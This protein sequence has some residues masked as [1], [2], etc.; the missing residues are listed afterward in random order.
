MRQSDLL[1]G[2]GRLLQ[3]HES[4]PVNLIG[5]TQSH[6]V[7]LALQ[8]SDLTVVQVSANTEAYLG[9]SPQV[10]LEK[11]FLEHLAPTSIE[12]LQRSAKNCGEHPSYISIAITTPK[13]V[14]SFDG[15]IHRIADCMVLE[16]EPAENCST[17]TLMSL[18][19]QIQ[20]VM[21]R[22]RHEQDITAFLQAAVNEIQGLTN[23]D[24]VMVYQ[25]DNHQAGAVVAE[26]KPS[27][28]ISYLGLHYPATDI[29]A[30]VRQLYQQ[31]L[32]RVIPDLTAPPIELV[33]PF[34]ESPLDLR[35]AILRGVDPCCISYHQN[36]DV[37][38]LMVIALVKNEQL[39]GLIACHHP[40]AKLVP[41][42]VRAACEILGHFIGAELANKVN[43]HELDDL[44]A[45]KSIQADFI[46]SIAS[47]KDFK[48]ALIHPEPSL[49]EV[50]RAPGAA[51]CLDDDI[52]L[53]GNTP[54]L[55]VVEALIKWVMADLDTDIFHTDSLCHHY[56]EAL[57]F[58]AVASGLLVLKISQLRRY[59]ILWFRPE[60]L[61]TIHWAGDPRSSIYTTEDGQV[62][63]CPRTSFERWQEMVQATATPWHPAE[64]AN[65]SALKH[66]IVGIVLNKAD[67]LAQMNLDLE[68]SNR[69]LDSFAYA[70][71]HD[72]KE[73]L[74]GI[75][76]FSNL[77]L[78]RYGQVL[79][80][81]GVKRLKTLVKLAHR[82]DDL[83]DALLRFSRLGQTELHPGPTDLNTL[84]PK[85]LEV[86][87]ASRPEG[88]ELPPIR[89]SRSFPMVNGDPVL[90]AEVFSNL[91]SNA[92]KYTNKPQPSIEIGVLDVD[93]QVSKARA[94]AAFMT[95]P[96]TCVLY[97][98]DDGIGIPPQHLQTVFRL[99]K[100]LH[101]RD[102]Y[103]G[104]TGAGLT[105]TQKIIERHGG[106]IW[107][108]SS[109]DAGT[110]FYFMLSCYKN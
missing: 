48:Q 69:E 84:I 31:G 68:R 64:I 16:L 50:V 76:N 7:L 100:R 67:E 38:G 58:K 18:Q 96:A 61:Q 21:A 12:P 77:I 40:T 97:V 30:L 45:L 9:V 39:W 91:L 24:R 110:T 82:M 6:G 35:Y 104:G 20:T 55:S 23:Y 25:F 71:S 72:L 3:D 14:Q 33:G 41:Y 88:T 75:T 15:Q 66:A 107:V 79:D 22:L 10:L 73:P 59:L 52:T 70:A 56:P 85:V 27:E 8:G 28:A 99:F 78:R 83:I 51:V 47:A 46:A 106:Q 44:S 34:L 103:G 62:I 94:D 42:S 54:G 98:R 92:L 65:A 95:P 93:E 26:I 86:L 60:V 102:S 2:P 19:K 74:R 37:T 36:M 105:I 5:I 109:Q 1:C 13:G 87:R 108:E 11:S 53:I 101:E 49:L 80:E 89:V 17:T 81:S 63:L 57:E 90:L 43:Q 32:V 29:P 4:Y